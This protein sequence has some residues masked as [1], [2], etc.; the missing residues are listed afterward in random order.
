MVNSFLAPSVYASADVNII[1][2]ATDIFKTALPSKTAV[3]IA[4]QKP[5]IFCFGNGS[6][7]ID[8]VQN[9]AN[10]LNVS[11]D[12]PEKLKEAILFV[13]DNPDVKGYKELF[14]FF[15]S[16]ENSQRYVDI[17]TTK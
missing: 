1:P 14:S 6:K 10:C 7:F 11:S 4:C 2:L 9:Q 16:T 3:C 12:D 15:K 5:I 8:F 17:I 13:K